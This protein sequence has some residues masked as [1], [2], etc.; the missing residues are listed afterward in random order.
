LP[1]L[2]APWEPF[3]QNVDK[4]VL[5]GGRFDII[6][7]ENDS[8]RLRAC[9]SAHNFPARIMNGRQILGKAGIRITQ[10]QDLACTLYSGEIFGKNAA[11]VVPHDLDHLA[12]VW[13]FCTSK[14]FAVAVRR[15]DQALK[16]T[17]ATI[18]KVPFDLAHWQKVAA[19]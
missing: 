9:P 10:M 2:C 11:T 7:W 6:L 14:D 3:I 17:N 5:F 16:V 18:A 15:I 1:T 13:C 4:T 8:G 12:A 19:E